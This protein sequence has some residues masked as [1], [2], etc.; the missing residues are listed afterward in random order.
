MTNLRGKVRAFPHSLAPREREQQPCVD[1]GRLNILV[2]RLY[3]APG[4]SQC[5]ELLILRDFYLL[6]IVVFFFFKFILFTLYFE[7]MCDP[8][9][10]AGTLL[11]PS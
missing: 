7:Q 11:L 6:S 1:V 10:T 8:Q 9:D 2:K 5:S 4:H 3:Q